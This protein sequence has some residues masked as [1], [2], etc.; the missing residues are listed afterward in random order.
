MVGNR[1]TV[2]YIISEQ[3]PH[4][5]ILGRMHN[6]PYDTKVSVVQQGN[7]KRV[8]VYCPAWVNKDVTVGP[9]YNADEFTDREILKE[10]ACSIY[11]LF[12]LNVYPV[13]ST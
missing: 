9:S 10:Q 2:G 8:H 11:S 4:D 13:Y 7:S 1:T 3:T 6:L 12:D 5:S